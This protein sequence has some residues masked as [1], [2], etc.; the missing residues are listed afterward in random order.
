MTWLTYAGLSSLTLVALALSRTAWES[1][2]I[3]GVMKSVCGHCRPLWPSKIVPYTVYYL[4]Q[5]CVQRPSL[6]S[7]SLYPEVG[8]A[9]DDVV[10]LSAMTG[11][12][13]TWRWRSENS[14][15]LERSVLPGF[16]FQT[17]GVSHGWYC[18]T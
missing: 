2:R 15:A 7:S 10:G 18:C 14:V 5:Y 12:A 13:G 8:A 9:V 16:T 4:V 3:E 17:G 11:L 1:A 6:K